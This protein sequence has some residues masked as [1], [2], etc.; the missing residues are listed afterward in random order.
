[1]ADWAG[2]VEE[3]ISADPG[4]KKTHEQLRAAL[5]S[6]DTD[7][8]RG[9]V[10]AIKRLYPSTD[11][12]TR[13]GLDELEPRRLKN[14]DNERR[15]DIERAMEQSLAE[16]AELDRLDDVAAEERV[17]NT[18]KNS[19]GRVF[20]TADGQ[21]LYELAD[22]RIVDNLDPDLQDMSWESLD[23]YMETTYDEMPIHEL[24]DEVGSKRASKV[25][26]FDYEKA[27]AL[28]TGDVPKEALMDSADRAAMIRKTMKLVPK[29][30]AVLGGPIGMGIAAASTLM[31]AKD[32]YA[33]TADTMNPKDEE[34][35]ARQRMLA[36]MMRRNEMP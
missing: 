20:V 31:D 12:D 25:P 27:A 6:N 29:L 9:K 13:L 21:Q 3:L 23:E 35:I 5:A 1:M 26:S 30:G 19:I 15:A 33:L 28:S 32:A 11:W 4:A 17:A 7:F 10:N 18:R 14:L 8:I 34:G 16:D 22:G 36:D 24:G 2:I